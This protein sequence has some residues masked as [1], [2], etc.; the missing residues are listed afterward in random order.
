MGIVRRYKSRRKWKTVSPIH[1][2]KE[3]K[4]TDNSS[5]QHSRAVPF[6]PKLAVALV[7][8]NVAL[9]L[10]E[11]CLLHK[12]KVLDATLIFGSADAPFFAQHF[13]S[14]IP[15]NYNAYMQRLAVPIVIALAVRSILKLI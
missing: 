12:L 2:N 15:F 4:S 7:V 13:N 8:T 3:P 14:S 10:L 11:L 9:L 6:S 1:P 5:Q